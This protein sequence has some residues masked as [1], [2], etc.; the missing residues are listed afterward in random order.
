[1][2]FGLKNAIGTF[3][4][5][6]SKMF[7]GLGDNFLNVFIDDFNVH[8][9]SWDEHLQNLHAVFFKLLKVTLKLNPNKS[10]FVANSITFL[11]HIVNN[12]STKPNLSKINAILTFQIQR[13]LPTFDHL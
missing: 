12:K 5:T 2:S 7:K 3:T 13:R 9:E 11:G 6:M 4:K 8:N 10:C 1:M